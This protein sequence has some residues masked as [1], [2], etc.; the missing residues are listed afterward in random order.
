MSK[1]Y[2]DD[3]QIQRFSQQIEDAEKQMEEMEKSLPVK[4]GYSVCTY[5]Y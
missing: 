1:D 2:H 4:I 3:D 5:W